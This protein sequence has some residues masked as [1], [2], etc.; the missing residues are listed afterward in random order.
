MKSIVSAQNPL[1]KDL[2][3]LA[4]NSAARAKS[5]QTLLD[6]T[7]VC[8]LYLE[9]RGAPALCVLSEGSVENVE[10]TA[11]VEQCEKLGVHVA[12]LTPSQYKQISP[13]VNGVGLLFLIETPTP[14]LPANLSRSAILIDRLQDPGNM[15]TILRSA[16]AAGV[17]NIYCAEG[18]AHAWS[19]KVVR[20]AMGA[21]FMLD[22]Y[23]GVD[24]R[25]VIASATIPVLGTSSHTTAAIY[26]VDLSGEVA[27]LVGHEGQGVD[28]SLLAASTQLVTI[29]H[30]GT[31]E[32]LNV[33]VATSVCLFEQTRQQ[34]AAA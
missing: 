30:A 5:G 32:S 12:M 4:T 33:A 13:V 19:P 7:H 1:F 3:K 15:G 29:P 26:D 14:E 11:I 18:T 25:A 23:Q 21:H 6:G 27:W 2:K 8:Q 20:A 24:L 31:M 17:R 34:R 22:I 9:Q 10:V 28:P 16:A